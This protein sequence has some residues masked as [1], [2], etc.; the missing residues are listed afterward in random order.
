MNIKAQNVGINSSGN[1]PDGSAMLDVVASDKGLLIPRV[2]IDDLTT[3]APVSSATTSLL[4]YNTNTTT[5]V[6]YHYWDGSKWVKLFDNNDGKQWKTLGNAGTTA[7]ANFLGTT[8]AVDVVFKANN[9]EQARVLSGSNHGIGTPNG[10]YALWGR[11]NA[12]DAWIRAV[13]P[14]YT[15]DDIYIGSGNNPSGTNI[16]LDAGGISNTAL[17]VQGSD[18]FIGIGTISPSYPLTVTS[19]TANI[20][21]AFF[22]TEASTDNIAIYGDASTTDYYGYGG[23]F[24]SGYIGVRANISATGSGSY[25]G[26]YS[27]VSGGTGNNYGIYATSDGDDGFGM[28]AKNT[29]TSG[30]GLLAI[31]NN[32]GGT[33][34][35]NGSAISGTGNT[36]GILGYAKDAGGTGLV[37]TGN[38]VSTITTLTGGSGVS[39]NGDECG[40][41]GIANSATGSGVLGQN[42]DANGWS[43]NFQGNTNIGTSTSDVHNFWGTFQSGSTSDSHIIVPQT[44]DYGYVGTNSLAW[45]Y[46]YSYNF[47]NPSRRELKRNINSIEGINADIIMHDIERMKP[48]IYKYKNETDVF[49]KGK[50][51]KYRPNMHLGLILDEVPDY[52][53]DNAFSG[54]DIY[55]L[56]TV[57]LTG[58]KYNRESIKKLQEKI[59]DFGSK[60]MNSTEIWI[61]FDSE[62]ANKLSGIVP[63]VTIS[64]NNPSVTISIT[65]KNSNGFKVVASQ[66]VPELNI[67]WI[68]MAKVE[69]KTVNMT[70]DEINKYKKEKQLIVSESDKFKVKNWNKEKTKRLNSINLKRKSVELKK[71]TVKKEQNTV[72][73]IKE[74]N[75]I[76]K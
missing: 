32:V 37:G 13:L 10:L 12:D 34:L 66:A 20:T 6:G 18:G 38:G 53:Q 67:D 4:V 57:A 1:T 25:Y 64:S 48:S 36:T 5:G 60:N 40:V 24:V 68:A 61:N 26:V 9:S 74:K 55:A 15:D 43:G 19:P 47:A 3:E 70:D 2:N 73:P 42:G 46:I 72:K 16:H 58:V 75:V 62:F 11:N 23:Y 76:V 14:A 69:V 27:T 29:N 56:G 35:T 31:G 7:G 71:S 54:V 33:Y 49:I 8:D 63:V 50:E 52:M 59:T 45:Y 28:Y 30:T 41:Y 65:E 22:N 44:D 51:A 21:G 17:F 39:G